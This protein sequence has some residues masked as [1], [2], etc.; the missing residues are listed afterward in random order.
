M[1]ILKEFLYNITIFSAMVIAIFG[2][3]TLAVLFVVFMTRFSPEIIAFTILILFILAMSAW[4]T[5]AE[6]R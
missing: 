4:K 1:K 3:A 5:W 6:R 2:S